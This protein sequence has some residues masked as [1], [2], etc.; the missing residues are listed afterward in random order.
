MSKELRFPDPAPDRE[1]ASA[2]RPVLAPPSDTAS[3]WD[4]LQRRIMARVAEAA[5]PITWWTLSPRVARVGLIAAG[6]AILALGALTMQ[7]REIETRIAYQAVTDTDLEVAR[8]IPGIDEPYGA[9]APV[10]R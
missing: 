2:L 1:I 9:T 3:Y 4:G 10:R 5:S 7:A 6:L 8:Y